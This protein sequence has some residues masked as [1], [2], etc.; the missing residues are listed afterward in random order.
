LMM[1]LGAESIF[2]GSGIFKSED[3]HQRARAI[4]A[5]A[6]YYND[7]EMLA[8]ISMGL[9][10]AMAGMDIQQMKKEDLLSSRGW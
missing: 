10:S 5:A 8:K 1:Q 6:T 7:P 3:P 2:V 9:L 4:V